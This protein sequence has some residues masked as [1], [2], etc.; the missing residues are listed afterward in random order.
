M[1]KEKQKSEINWRG[2]S[3]DSISKWWLA[4]REEAISDDD[5]IENDENDDSANI[6]KI[7][8]SW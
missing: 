3:N 5:D 2:N 8:Y 7:F 6:T 1:M 4:W